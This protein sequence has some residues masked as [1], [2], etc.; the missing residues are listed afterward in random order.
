MAERRKRGNRAGMGKQCPPLPTNQP[1]PPQAAGSVKQPAAASTA[2]L[3]QPDPTM[4]AHPVAGRPDR[5]EAQNVQPPVV[6]TPAPV[7]LTSWQVCGANVIGLKHLRM[8]L[9][10]QDAVGWR[11]SQRPILALSDGAGSA[12][13]SERGANELVRGM[14]RFFTTMED[15]LSPWLDD[16]PN[17]A[18]DQAALW[19]RRLLSHAQGLLADLA[20]QERRSVQDVR[21]TLLLAVF[22][23]MHVFWW[24]VGDGVIVARTD[25]GLHVVGKASKAKGE[26]ANQTCFVDTASMG[27]VQYGVLPSADTLGLALMSDGGAE[28]LVAHD[29]SKVSSLIGSWLDELAQ[30]TLSPDKL[31]L[32]YHEPKMWER[33]TLDDRSIVLAARPR[34]CS[35]EH[36]AP[37]ASAKPTIETPPC[38]SQSDNLQAEPSSNQPQA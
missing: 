9:P 28:K 5:A 24:Q 35:H 31:A 18:A 7:A 3:A 4:A 37:Q 10:C 26:F 29:G 22:G 13:I 6:A 14:M 30:Q 33:T 11:T 1:S 25:H 8:G 27:D 23:S 34:P 2:N 36:D 38:A 16:G 21:A 20:K 32:A 12:V 19:A 17:T 15:A